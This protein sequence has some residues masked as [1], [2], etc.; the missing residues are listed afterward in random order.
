MGGDAG[1]GRAQ[2]AGHAPRVGL[3][4]QDRAISRHD[5]EFIGRARAHARDKD[6]PDANVGAAAHRMFAVVPIVE[7]PHHANQRGIGRPDREMHAIA[8]FVADAMRAQFVE[9]PQMAAL[10]NQIVV[11]RPQHR[12]IGKASSTN[13]CAP[14]APTR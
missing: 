8:A 2:F 5:A 1:G 12:A 13:Q 14:K 9:Q 10:G 3:E 7:I 4:R 6:F 11:E